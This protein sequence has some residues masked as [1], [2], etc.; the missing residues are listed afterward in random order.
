MGLTRAFIGPWPHVKLSLS[1]PRSL[2]DAFDNFLGAR[3][4]SPSALYFAG[5]AANGATLLT[6]SPPSLATNDAS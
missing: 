6:E 3:D 2:F 1:F 5:S 4:L